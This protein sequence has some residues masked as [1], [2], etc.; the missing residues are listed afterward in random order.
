MLEHDF[1]LAH[2]CEE[3]KGGSGVQVNIGMVLHM[4]LRVHGCV[5][6]AVAQPCVCAR[7]GFRV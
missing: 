6:G 2:S 4:C 1:K 7:I 5:K 3:A